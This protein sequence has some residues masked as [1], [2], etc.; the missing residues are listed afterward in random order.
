MSLSLLSFCSIA[1]A[2]F[3]MSSSF[4][5]C[6]CSTLC[7]LWICSSI[8][9]MSRSTLL[10]S[11]SSAMIAS[12]TFVSSAISFWN[13]SHSSSIGS[14]Y[15]TFLALASSTGSSKK[16]SG[17]ASAAFLFF[18]GHWDF[19]TEVELGRTCLGG[20]I[21]TSKKSLGS[22]DPDFSVGPCLGTLLESPTSMPSSEELPEI[23]EDSLALLWGG[24]SLEF[25]P[26]CG[27]SL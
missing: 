17:K 14:L 15:S 22:T 21:G 3:F 9:S 4:L 26:V 24:L 6:S 8:S 7:Q 1:L 13:F 20:A 2:S 19:G 18:S 27:P 12:D 11:T 23:R 16:P 10:S 5:C 25:S